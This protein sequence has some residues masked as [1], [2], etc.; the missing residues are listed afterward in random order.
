MAAWHHLADP[1]YLDVASSLLGTRKPTSIDED[2]VGTP[3]IHQVVETRL[4][5]L[6]E[7]SAEVNACLL[8]GTNQLTAHSLEEGADQFQP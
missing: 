8:Q 4:V 7:L 3:F 6:P 5:V 2:Q 1:G